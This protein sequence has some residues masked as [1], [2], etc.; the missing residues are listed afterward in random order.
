MS[1][2]PPHVTVHQTNF[3]AQ[4]PPVRLEIHASPV[5]TIGVS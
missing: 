2:T 4:H 3:G 5:K 1:E